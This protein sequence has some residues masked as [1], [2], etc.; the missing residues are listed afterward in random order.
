MDL[1]EIEQNLRDEDTLVLQEKLRTNSFIEEVRIIVE[2]ILTERNEQIPVAETEEEVE[3]KF[4]HNSKISLLILV[5]FVIYLLVLYL[6][7]VTTFRFICFTSALI[8]AVRY[9]LGLKIK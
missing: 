3:E 1:H 6:G 8:F 9:M 5:L 7:K 2:K 4:A